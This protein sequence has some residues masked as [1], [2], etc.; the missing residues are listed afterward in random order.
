MESF[1]QINQQQPGPRLSR[2]QSLDSM[3]TAPLFFS[4][5][6]VYSTPY[7]MVA[8]AGQPEQAPY[9]VESPSCSS[10]LDLSSINFHDRKHFLQG[11]ES[12]RD[13]L[14]DQAFTGATSSPLSRV[15]SFFSNYYRSDQRPFSMSNVSARV[16]SWRKSRPRTGFAHHADV[17]SK[18]VVDEETETAGLGRGGAGA[19]GRCAA[20]ER[21]KCCVRFTSLV[22]WLCMTLCSLAFIL[23]VTCLLY[24]IV[25]H[26]HAPSTTLKRVEFRKFHV[27]QGYD[28]TGVPTEILSL[29]SMVH[30]TFR[31]PSKHYATLVSP[32]SSITFS[33][34]PRQLVHVQ[35]ARFYQQRDSQSELMVAAEAKYVPLYGAGPSM[36]EAIAESRTIEL[37]LTIS[38]TATVRLFAGLMTKEYNQELTCRVSLDPNTGIVTST[39]CQSPDNNNNHQ[40]LQ[41]VDDDKLFPQQGS[42]S[43]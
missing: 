20:H 43:P 17:S 4:S 14:S 32:S 27:M 6:S 7:N 34:L 39:A 29:Q 35:V 19:A 23:A 26:P 25:C 31:N 16:H 5:A 10:F 40:Q 28:R 24:W 3:S 36:K 8:A 41:D 22:L 2:S 12:E 1:L 15:G 42:G 38:V 37:G 30:L 18:W 13:G 11:E 33:Y 21:S 9:Y